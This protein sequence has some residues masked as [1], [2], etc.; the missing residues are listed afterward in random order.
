MSAY[1]APATCYRS[2]TAVVVCCFHR[3]AHAL[4]LSISS[5]PIFFKPSPKFIFSL[6]FS[7]FEPYIVPVGN[8]CFFSS[9]LSIL[10]SF[11]PN[12]P[13]SMAIIV[14]GRWRLTFSLQTL[15]AFQSIL[16]SSLLFF[17]YIPGSF[18]RCRWRLMFSLSSDVLVGNPKCIS[19]HLLQSSLLFFK[20]IPGSF[21]RCRWRLTF[22]LSSDVLVGNP[23]CI[24]KHLL[25]S[26]LLF[27][28]YIPGS[29]YRC[30]WRLTFS[31]SSDVLVGNPKCISKHLA[32]FFTFL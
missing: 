25:Q 6:Y 15:N 23:K 4:P 32:I 11:S 3:K 19:K 20:Y 22:S 13:G 7:G 10:F 17:K 21:Y 2:Y 16:Q 8:M 9:H 30:R 28:K 1:T 5:I 26:S 14:S 18:Y 12:M 27:F 24:S 31:L 29:F